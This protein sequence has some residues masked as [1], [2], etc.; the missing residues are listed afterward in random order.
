LQSSPTQSRLLL[1]FPLFY[2]LSDCRRTLSA[3]FFLDFLRPV[4]ARLTTSRPRSGIG[5]NSPPVNPFL[6]VFFIFESAFSFLCPLPLRLLVLPF[7]MIR[8]VYVPKSIRLTRPRRLDLR[9]VYRLRTVFFRMFSPETFPVIYIF[10]F[11]RAGRVP[12]AIY[13]QLLI[14]PMARD[15][16]VIVSAYE[17]FSFFSSWVLG[18]AIRCITQFLAAFNARVTD[19]PFDFPFSPVRPYLRVDVSLPSSR[20]SSTAEAEASGLEE[21]PFAGRVCCLDS[22]F[23]QYAK[24]LLI[25]IVLLPFYVFCNSALRS[26]KAY[27]M[28]FQELLSFLLCW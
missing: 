21:G 22:F 18:C 1:S 14:P 28:K 2:N 16:T 15:L 6:F 5:T 23:S 27:E 17:T 9:R 20:P 26:F 7:P 12:M 10:S 3:F 24:Q 8:S 19:M 11:F 13:E 25:A 4:A